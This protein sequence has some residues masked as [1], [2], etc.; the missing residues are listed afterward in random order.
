MNVVNSEIEDIIKFNNEKI[1]RP[2]INNGH[3]FLIKNN[4][5]IRSN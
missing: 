2:F 1:S 4:A 3:F 5:I